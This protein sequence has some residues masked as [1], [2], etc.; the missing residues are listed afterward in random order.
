MNQG[1]SGDPV[2]EGAQSSA[3]QD[4]HYAISTVQVRF[5]AHGLDYATLE[6]LRVR[7]RSWRFCIYF[8]YHDY[9]TYSS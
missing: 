5:A 8:I 7:K 3:Y 4:Y 2:E 6:E 9:F 1:N